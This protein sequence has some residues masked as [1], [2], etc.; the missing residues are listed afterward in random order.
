MRIRVPLQ[1][2]DRP[3]WELK[4]GWETPLFF[5]LLLPAFPNATTLFIEGASVSRDVDIFL[6]SAAEPGDYLAARQTIWPRPK[7]YKVRCDGEVL[8]SLADLAGR[9]AEPELLDHLFVYD[10]VHVLIEFPDAFGED[11]PAFITAEA[12]EER[13]RGFAAAL[14]LDVTDMRQKHHR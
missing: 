10:A 5:R 1:L 12:N 8:A 4:G 9:H 11:C 3:H 14:G 7:Q 13:I 6:R 2:W